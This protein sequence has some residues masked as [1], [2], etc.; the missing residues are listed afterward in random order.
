MSDSTYNRD[1]AQVAHFFGTLNPNGNRFKSFET[2]CEEM[3]KPETLE[4]LHWFESSYTLTAASYAAR[5][6]YERNSKTTLPNREPHKA[7]ESRTTHV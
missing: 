2:Y 6:N 5:I 7:T 1:V 4:A 3:L